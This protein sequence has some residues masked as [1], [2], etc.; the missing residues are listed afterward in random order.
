MLKHR[1]PFY[2]EAALWTSFYLSDNLCAI[3]KSPDHI[4]SGFDGLG[5]IRRHGASKRL[6]CRS[7]FDICVERAR[8]VRAIDLRHTFAANA[9]GSEG[10]YVEP[11]ATQSTWDRVGGIIGQIM[12]A[13]I[14]LGFAGLCIALPLI[15]AKDTWPGLALLIVPALPAILTCLWM[16]ETGSKL[17]HWYGQTLRKIFGRMPAPARART[18]DAVEAASEAVSKSAGILGDAGVSL[19]RGL[20]VAALY[21]FLFAIVAGTGYA[22]FQGIAA[23]PTSTAIV[24]GAMIIAWAVAKR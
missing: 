22:V 20:A 5:G 3:A 11:E 2:T 6:L 24:L 1:P 18:S 15:L 9:L 13:P 4:A 23:L 16:P 17:W 12:F 8:H 10:V 7:A 14:R 21:V 19:F